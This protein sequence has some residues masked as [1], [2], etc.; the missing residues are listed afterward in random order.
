MHCDLILNTNK[1]CVTFTPVT[2]RPATFRPVPGHWPER[3]TF[4]PVPG[5]FQASKV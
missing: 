2:F 1:G 4:R 5:D 3:E